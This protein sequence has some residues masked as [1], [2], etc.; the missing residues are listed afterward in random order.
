MKELTCGLPGDYADPEGLLSSNL[1][2]EKVESPVA[3]E[4]QARVHLYCC[5]VLFIK[6]KNQAG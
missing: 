1:K 6:K 2:I 4:L 3:G 5:L